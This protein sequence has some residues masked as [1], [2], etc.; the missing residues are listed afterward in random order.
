MAFV[1]Q[2]LGW[3][4]KSQKAKFRIRSAELLT[5]WSDSPSSFLSFLTV[6]KLTYQ[7]YAPLT[8]ASEVDALQVSC[9]KF[10]LQSQRKRNRQHVKGTGR[11]EIPK[12]L[13]QWRVILALG[14]ECVQNLV[15]LAQIAGL[16]ANYPV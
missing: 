6:K 5:L 9:E 10:E 1:E 3:H 2:H 11:T 14:Y 15:T 12:P 4:K 13:A 8:Q 7:Y 16:S